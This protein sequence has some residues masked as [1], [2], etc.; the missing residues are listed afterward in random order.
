MKVG[1]GPET[2]YQCV[3]ALQ[4]PQYCW[5]KVPL[6]GADAFR[7]LAKIPANAAILQHELEAYNPDEDRSRTPYPYATF[8][9]ECAYTTDI[10]ENGMVYNNDVKRLFRQYAVHTLH[11]Q[12]FREDGKQG[13]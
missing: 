10:A 9:A 1:R 11:R 7:R 3:A 12:H 5:G 6:R 2:R 13:C 4:V 8:L